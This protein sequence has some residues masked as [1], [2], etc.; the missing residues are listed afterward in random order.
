MP[1]IAIEG[2]AGSGVR[3]IGC[4]VADNL[5]IDFVDRI[6]IAEVARRV[7]ATVRAIAERET[8]VPSL[9]ER[10]GNVVQKMLKRSSVT[11]MGGDPYFGPGVEQILARSYHD[12]DEPPAASAVQMDEKQFALTTREVIQEV[13][14]N[15]NAVILNRAAAA[16]LKDDRRV[17][18]IG[19]VSER[20]DR[21]RRIMRQRHLTE[22]QANDFVKHSDAA[23]HRYFLK[24]FDTTPL[25][26]FLYHFMC[27]ASDV[28]DE[29]ASKVIE[30]AVSDMNEVGLL[31]ASSS[32]SK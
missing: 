12:M 8:K 5:G 18:R 32:Q 31:V 7:G 6:I 28:S 2:R 25:D 10:L 11:G 30:N 9:S 21:V 22:E 26:P 16:I 19:I 23:Q 20:K 13:A 1:V 15:G 17:L 24:F 3:D 14:E 29:Y 27:N 4:M